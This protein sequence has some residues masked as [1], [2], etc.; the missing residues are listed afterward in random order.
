MNKALHKWAMDQFKACVDRDAELRA[1]QMDD[2]RFSA[3]DQWPSA[4]RNLRE[5]DPNG[6]RPCLTID[7]ITQYRQ[8]IVNE[9]RKNRPGIKVRPVDDA[10]DVEVAKIYQ[11]QIRFIEDRSNADIAYENASEWAIDVGEGYLRVITEMDGDGQEICIK[12]IP[13]RFSVY[14]G[15]HLM[16]DGS[17]AKLCFITEDVAKDEFRKQYPK[18][19]YKTE[20]LEA[21]G[22][23]A[24]YW[25]TDE[26]VRI[27]EC[28]YLESSTTNVLELEDGD[29]MG[30]KEYWDSKDGRKIVNTKTK[31]KE[32]CEWIK[33]TSAEILE[34]RD[35]PC[36]YIPV[37]KVVG[38]ERI[39]DGK[40]DRWGII[41]PSKDSQRLYNYWASVLTEN[42]GLTARSKWVVAAG[43]IEG[44]EQ[45]WK[46]SNNSTDPF[47]T[48]NPIDVNGQPVQR[49]EK[50]PAGSPDV[51]ILQQL[52]LIEHDIQTSLG[53]F[54]ACLLYTSD[55]ADE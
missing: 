44:F 41:R 22:D 23:H 8:Q 15:V 31:D 39:V 14:M 1:K 27:A 42:L 26:K 16:P 49:P 19:K 13:N 45:Q 52:K 4:I 2:W 34:E 17:D 54:R 33:M 12:P 55:A 9:I 10:A 36:K 50:V 7:K 35:F 25:E 20:D 18:A 28:F 11:E 53:M 43:Q 30:E 5:N 29:E 46:K 38:H 3:L 24:D 47:L 37:I 6:P 48:Y 32:V 51:A 40:I 21:P